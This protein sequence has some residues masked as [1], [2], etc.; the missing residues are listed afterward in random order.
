MSTLGDGDGSFI[1]SFKEYQN[2]IFPNQNDN[3][4]TQY[5]DH[6]RLPDLSTIIC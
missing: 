2:W 3:S 6:F 1:L 4:F 5:V